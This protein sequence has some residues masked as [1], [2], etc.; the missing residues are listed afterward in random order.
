MPSPTADSDDPSALAARQLLLEVFQAALTRVEGEAAVRA[1]LADDLPKRAALLAVGKA[2]D[3]MAQ[4]AVA[5]L[6]EGLHSGLIVTKYGHGEPDHWQGLPVTYLESAHPVPDHNSLKAGERIIEFVQTLPAELPLLCLISGGASA[7]VE[8]PWPGIDLDML[9]RA[10][11]WLLGSGLDIHQVNRVRQGL[12][13]IKG[14]GLL[15]YVGER[16]VIGLYISDVAGDDPAVIGSGLLG[17][18]PEVA[19]PQ[20]LPAWLVQALQPPHDARPSCTVERHIIAS[21][22]HAL[23]AAV[24]AGEQR[25]CPVQRA[26]EP[27]VGDAAETAQRIVTVLIDGP[28]GLYLWGGETTVNLPARPGRGGRNQQLALA[29]AL[30][31]SGRDDIFLLAAGTDGSDGPTEDAGALV[32]GSTVARGKLHGFDAADCL[33]RADAGNL[34]EASGDL[35]STGPTG[36]NVTDLV[37]AFKQP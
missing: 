8:A 33:A 36:T 18:L 21:L 34:L 4:G 3:A 37:I 27:L 9:Q 35:V 6:G 32:D 10:N 19:P 28:P 16:R 1:A 29:A 22:D 31:I 25:G 26:T 14:G 13:R 7:L 11:A 24:A 5:M 20:A 17:P 23:S 30:A 15:R 2:A 12:S